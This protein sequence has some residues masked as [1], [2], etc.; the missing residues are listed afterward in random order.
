[1]DSLGL[2]FG[3]GIGIVL[4]KKKYNNFCKLEI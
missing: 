3:A 2:C 4:E 1:M